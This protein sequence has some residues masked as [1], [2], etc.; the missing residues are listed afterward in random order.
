MEEMAADIGVAVS[1]IRKWIAKHE[2]LK[3]AVVQGRTFSDTLVENSLL[4]RAMGMKI[5]RRKTINKTDS[6]GKQLPAKIETYEEEVP[7]DT[8]ACIFWLK[9]REPELWRDRQ[10]VAVSNNEWVKALESVVDGKEE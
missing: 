9:N 3:E 6:N 4:K 8:T 7:P 5:V 2:E 1:T 10:E